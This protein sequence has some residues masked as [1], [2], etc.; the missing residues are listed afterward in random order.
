M[1]RSTIACVLLAFAAFWVASSA[2]SNEVRD[3]DAAIDG[4]EFGLLYRCGF[5]PRNTVVLD[6]D[7]NDLAWGAAPWHFVDHKTGTGPAPNDEN[8]SLQFAAVAD[9]EWL[10]VAIDVTDDEIQNAEDSA[11][12]V[13]KDDSVEIYIDADD[14]GTQT[15]D[16]EEGKWDTQISIGA[17]NFDGDPE[18]PILGG[19]GQGPDTGTH[20]AVV[21]TATGYIVEAAVPLDSPGKWDFALEDGLVIGFN[22]HMND[23]DDGG[24]RDNKLI[25]SANDVDDQS[26]Q[27]PSRFADL[28]FVSSLLAVDPAGKAATTWG[29]LR[30]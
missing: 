24:E 12:D 30:R 13:W 28:E 27:N 14:G 18:A 11:G 16:A 9:N 19:S 20:A 7:L 25:W 5:G 29:A 4:G 23:D 1:K 8:A 15:Y 17:E 3:S 22:I 26:W 21:E 2:S 6:G 10:Y